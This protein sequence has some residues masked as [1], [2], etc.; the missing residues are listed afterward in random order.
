MDLF[1]YVIIFHLIGTVLGVGGATFVEI[2]INKALK[3]GEIDPV[4]SSFLKS[5]FTTVRIGLIISL[6][7]GIAFL[8]I[9]RFEGQAFRMYDP[10]LWAKMTML[11]IIVL[12]AL[13]LQTHKMPLWLGSAL[14]FVSWYGVLIAGVMLSGP[15]VPYLTVMFVYAIGLI[16]SISF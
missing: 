9:Y 12:N 6:V 16:V 4:E 5:T 3:D 14:S 2:N 7:T 11:G 13:L 1:T 10:V 8:L 15:E